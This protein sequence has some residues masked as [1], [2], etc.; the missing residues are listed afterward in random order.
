MLRGLEEGGEVLAGVGGSREF[1][2]QDPEDYTR[3]GQGRQN[4]RTDYDKDSKKEG[5]EKGPHFMQRNRGSSKSRLL[6]SH[7]RTPANEGIERC[8]NNNRVKKRY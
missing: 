6:S 8:R 3:Q 2:E 5:K 7:T 4:Q 1:S